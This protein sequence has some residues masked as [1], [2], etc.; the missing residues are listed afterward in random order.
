[1]QIIRLKEVAEAAGV[2]ISTAAAA[3]RGEGMVKASTR[4]RVEEQAHRLGYRKNTAASFM[5]RRV[6]R[7]K[8]KAVF[9]AWLTAY[10]LVSKPNYPW[11]SVLDYARAAAE[12]EGIIFDH[13]NVSTP[14]DVR[15]ILRQIRARGCDGIV[16]GRCLADNLPAFPWEEFCVVSTEQARAEEGFDVIRSNFF[17]NTLNLLIHLRRSGYAR[18]A[19]LLREHTPRHPDDE[20]RYGG[21]AAFLDLHADPS[22]RIPPLVL[23]YRVKDI[24]QQ[25]RAWVQKYKPQ[26]VVGSN[27]EEYRILQEAGFDVPHNLSYVALHVMEHQR[28]KIAGLQHNEEIIPQVALSVLLEKMRHGVRGLSGHPREIVVSPPFLAGE[29]C[30]GISPTGY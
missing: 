7:S 19:I 13:F 2:S 24:V 18:I 4:S 26:V 3:L 30:S 25:I 17:R 15:V 10:P 12:T 6:N 11:K 14:Q 23:T 22:N 9:A 28:G 5:S 27:H 16:W 21:T 20:A 29:S 8:Q 1:M